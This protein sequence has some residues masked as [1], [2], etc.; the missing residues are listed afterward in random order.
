M[1]NVTGQW[2]GGENF[3]DRSREL[4][5]YWRDLET[6]NLLLLAPRRV[7]K[8]SVMK[9]MQLD[10]EQHGYCAVFIDVSDAHAEPAFVRRLYQG[11]LESDAGNGL[12]NRLKDSWLGKA[13]RRVRKVGGAG[14]TVEFDADDGA[15]WYSL[16][17]ELA[18][19]LSHLDGRWLIQVDELPVF[20]LQLLRRDDPRQRDSVREFLYW[21]RRLRLDFPAV[22]W[23]LAGSIGLDTVAARLNLAD[24]VNDLRIVTLGA[25]NRETAHELLLELGRR[26]SLGLSEPVRERLIDRIG[27]PIPYYLQLAFHEL[28]ELDTEASL[29]IEDVDHA[30]D[31]LLDPAHR[32]YF[33]YW[34]QRLHDELGRPDSDYAVQLLTSA[35]LDANGVERSTLSQVLSAKVADPDQRSEKL[36]YLLD[37]LQSDGYLVEHQGRWRF[38]VPLLRD[39]WLRR[40]A[41]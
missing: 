21:M 2:V 6:D 26:Y 23:M 13:V 11:V 38:R 3:F 33:D 41:P 1:Q 30:F 17:R 18:D 34:R 4:K 32:A 12:W 31:T 14:F 27:W 15:D 20:V 39:Y 9:R 24:A 8:T 40:V 28:R 16:G 5:R 7:G 35:A 29:A 37:V 19:A 25:Y 36:R 22:R 10:A